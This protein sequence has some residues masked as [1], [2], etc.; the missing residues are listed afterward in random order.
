MA[1]AMSDTA[2][3]G[4]MLRFEAGL[5]TVEGRL[6]LI[7][8]GAAESIA[9]ACDPAG[10]D[11][12]AIGLA[13]VASATPA[14]PVVDAL[15]ARCPSEVA[16][17]VHF[18][19]TSQ[20]VIDT[21]MMLV[22]RDG[23]RLL[24]ADLSRLATS[25][26]ELAERHRGTVMAGRTLL[27]QAR[28]IT[29]GLKASGWL[30]GV[31][32]ASSRLH[33]IHDDGLAV[34]LGGASGTLDAL[35][36]R[37]LEV[38]QALAVELELQEPT[39]SWHSNRTRVAE[40]GAALV[41]GAGAAAKIA[42]DVVLLA[43]TEVGEVAE[44]HPGRSSAMAHKRNPARAVEAR[45][46]F[47]SLVAQGGILL[48]ALPGEHERAAGTWQAEWPALSEAFRLAAGAVARTREAV[49]DIEVHADRM[50]A[51]VTPDLNPEELGAA[52]TLIDRALQR[53]RG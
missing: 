15:R 47:D 50:R 46:A 3:L 14:I 23:L 26:A 36:T 31:L 40:L 10:F 1:L 18:G 45:A 17:H 43:Q 49:A 13:A 51:N 30:I 28:P 27:Q 21:A 5:A 22:A 33:D 7:P 38:M 12:D 11:V 42:L 37:G 4:A 34:Q 39:L 6:G 16:G 24:L 29:F 48:R 32:D 20:D 9:A 25:C 52:D 19:A 41:V 2:W 35:G 53:F 44:A 8:A